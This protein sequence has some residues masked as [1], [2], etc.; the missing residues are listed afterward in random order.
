MKGFG[1][2]QKDMVKQL[3]I[4]NS[5]KVIGLTAKMWEMYCEPCK[6]RS[7]YV[8]PCKECLIKTAPVMQEI[9]D[10]QDKKGYVKK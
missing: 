7:P 3:G 6:K 1:K 5:K 10:I 2:E 9:K 8:P 4:R